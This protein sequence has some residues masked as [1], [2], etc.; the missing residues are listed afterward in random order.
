MKH[1]LLESLLLSQLALFCNFEIYLGVPTDMARRQARPA[2][3]VAASG[4]PQPTEIISVI[5]VGFVL[6]VTAQVDD[7]ASDG[8]EGEE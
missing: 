7:R 8:S 4:R 1:S 6:Q 5:P 3:A 2:F